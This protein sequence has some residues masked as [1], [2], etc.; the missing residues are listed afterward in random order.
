M[1]VRCLQLA[2]SVL[3]IAYDKAALQGSLCAFFFS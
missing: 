2:A 3:R 1:Q